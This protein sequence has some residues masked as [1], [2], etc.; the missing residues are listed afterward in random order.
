VYI[1]NQ[2]SNTEI[3]SLKNFPCAAKGCDG[4]FV[5]VFAVFRF[6]VQMAGK[7]KYPTK[8]RNW[9]STKRLTKAGGNGPG[10]VNLR[11]LSRVQNSNLVQITRNVDYG[12]YNMGTAG[13]DG[14]YGL[15]FKL[16]DAPSYTQFTALFDE[17]RIT[18][19]KLYWLPCF[20]VNTTAAAE[21]TVPQ[22][23]S[24]I[25]YDDASTP[26]SA[27]VINAFDTLRV[28]GMLNKM[29]T[30]TLKPTVALATYTT[31]FVGYA[32][33]QD[34][35]IDCN[36]PATTH[37]GIKWGMVDANNSSSGWAH[38]LRATFYIDFRKAV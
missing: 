7:R 27:N 26:G 9:T 32:Q 10:K 28:H 18:A 5:S 23:I 29:Y 20:S 6:L 14:L 35:W 15:S 13:T 31:S 38:G 17:Y 25:D 33:R 16:S 8:K 30:R 37:Y 2:R 22:L 36:S 11:T 34:Q 4:S 21:L 1:P 3:R 24:A 12:F 19:I